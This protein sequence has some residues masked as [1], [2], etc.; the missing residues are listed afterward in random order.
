MVSIFIDNSL[1]IFFIRNNL[2]LF[3]LF[4]FCY[5]DN[6]VV[7]IYYR[8]WFIFK[9]LLFTFQCALRYVILSE[10]ITFFIVLLNQVDVNT[11]LKYFLSFLFPFLGQNNKLVIFSFFD[12]CLAVFY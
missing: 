7:Q 11:F 10:C 4:L 8:F 6:L 9:G 12:F 1:S 5:F 2:L 3:Y